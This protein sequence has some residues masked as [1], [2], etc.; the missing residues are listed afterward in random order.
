MNPLINIGIKAVRRAGNLIIRHLD[1]MDQF[2][3]TQKGRNDF[4]SEVDLMA[5]EE[6]IGCIH[7]HYPDHAIVAEESGTKHSPGKGTTKDDFEWIIDPLDGTTNFLHGHPN[8]AVSIGV[9]HKN[10]MEHGIIF[11]P[12]RNEIFHASRGS[13][14]QMNDRRIRVSGQRRLSNSLVLSGFPSRHPGQF[15][16]WTACF[17]DIFPLVS[18]SLHSGSAA[19]DL[20]YVACGRGDAYWESGLNIWDMAAGSLIVREAGGLVTGFQGEQDHLSTGCV[21]AAS[22][23][24]F[25]DILG[26]VKSRFPKDRPAP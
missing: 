3:V 11:D 23:G 22:P 21:I 9:R 7:Y 25:S 15:D 8:F 13:G 5:E 6:I 20:A 12:L 26:I 17:R 1:R 16:N 24:I 10:R 14:A 18:Q 4:V 2:P 19:L